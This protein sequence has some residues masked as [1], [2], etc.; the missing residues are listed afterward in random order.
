MGLSMTDAISIL[1]QNLKK[2][3][4]KVERLR[5]QL[6]AAETELVES[7]TAIRV[8]TRLGLSPVVEGAAAE[9]NRGN[10]HAQVLGVLPSSPDEAKTPKEIHVALLEAGIT[11]I[12]PDNVRTILYRSAKQDAN[13]KAAVSSK[14][15]RYWRNDSAYDAEPD[16][17]GVALDEEDD[18]QVFRRVDPALGAEGAAVAKSALG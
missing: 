11:S 7:E 14:D 12:T 15:S 5:G 13:G 3:R 10:S 4:V 8:L 9:D 6:G 16:V 18:E 17:S 1:E 2:L